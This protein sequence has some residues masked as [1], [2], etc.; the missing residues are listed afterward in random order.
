MSTGA[1]RFDPDRVAYYEAAGWRAYYDRRWLRLFRLTASLCQEQ[2][3]VPFPMSLLAAYWIARG[4]A[5]WVPLDHDTGT[6]LHYYRRFFRLAARYAGLSFDPDRVARLEMTYWD[7]HRRLADHG[8]DSTLLV[9]AL[10][11]LHAGVFNL[12]PEQAR[13][14][15]ESRAAAA[16]IVDGITKGRSRNVEGD[17]ARLEEELRACYR[18]LQRATAP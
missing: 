11:E 16:A 6:V 17:W 4:A 8:G 13:P 9:H 2:F 1:Q 14:S 15:A 12:T 18:L 7:V 3:N 10:T 5:A